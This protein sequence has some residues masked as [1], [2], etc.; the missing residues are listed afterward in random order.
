MKTNQPDLAAKIREVPHRPGVYVYRDRLGRIIY[1]G[2]ARDLRKRI[3]QYFH[4]SRRTTGDRKT[5]ALVESVWDVE[6]HVVRSEPEAILLEGRLIKEY[7]P[8]Y[9][10]SFR[11][12]KKFLLAKINLNDPYPRF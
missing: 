9:N 1:V 10:V 8:R 5:Q 6:T 7:R 4:P 3:S 12:D 2:K 11:D